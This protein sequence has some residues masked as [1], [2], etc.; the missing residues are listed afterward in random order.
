MGEK[1]HTL[2]TV[3]SHVSW[4]SLN[5]TTEIW[6]HKNCKGTFFK[7]EYLEKQSDVPSTRKDEGEEAS[8]MVG[9]TTQTSKVFTNRKSARKKYAYTPPWKDKDLMKCIICDE[10]KRK[11]D[12][13]YH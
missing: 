6:T 8:N 12:V 3:K 2:N 11:K 9:T 1:N 13:I 4:E 5:N 10:E 7:T